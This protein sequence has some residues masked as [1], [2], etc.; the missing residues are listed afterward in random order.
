MEN[1]FLPT[2]PSAASTSTLH[3]PLPPLSRKDLPPRPP[4]QSGMRPTRPQA[5]AFSQTLLN[6]LGPTFCNRFFRHLE[7]TILGISEHDKPRVELARM[8]EE[9]GA[10]DLWEAYLEI[11]MPHWRGEWK[12][13]ES[14][15][16]L[17]EMFSGSLA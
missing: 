6:R 15:M 3:T 7:R 17:L 1:G 5:I 9:E 10:S 2:Y 4:R 13:E 12:I 14:E 11:F 16:E 8:F